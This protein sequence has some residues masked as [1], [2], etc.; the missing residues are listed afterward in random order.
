MPRISSITSC[1]KYPDGPEISLRSKT[2]R[3]ANNWRVEKAMDGNSDVTSD[4]EKYDITFTKGH[5]AT[6]SANY[7]FFGA[8]YAYTTEG[9]WS[10]ASNNEKLVVDYD[11]DSADR[12]YIILRL[13]EDEMWLREEGG[14][15]VLHLVTR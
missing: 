12:T 4:F 2:E 5:R 13:M 6:L 3:V 7:K 10:F 11:S 9:T 14:T 15:L 1:K 8:T